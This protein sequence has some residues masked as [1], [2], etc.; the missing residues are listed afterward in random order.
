MLHLRLVGPWL[1]DDVDVVELAHIAEQ[2]LRGRDVERGQRRTGQVVRRAKA[3]ESGDCEG[4][5]RAL[6][7]DPDPLTHL[8]VVLLR[9]TEIH[10]HVVRRGRACSLGQVECRDLLVRVEGDAERWR[11]AGCDRLA[12]M[13][14]VLR[15]AGDRPP[16]RL[17]AGDGA[18][19]RHERLGDCIPGGVAAAPELRDPADLEVDVLVDVPEE[20]VER[21]VQRVGEHESPGDE[22]DAQHDRQSGEREAE[23]VREE[24]F[25]GHPPHV[26]SPTSALVPGRNRLSARR[27]RRRCCRQRGRR[28]GRRMQHHG[29][30]ASP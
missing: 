27:G 11:P 19:A 15:I 29:G 26:R 7:Q 16:C 14:D 1:R 12:V 28:R 6:Q 5:G 20:R 23:L 3:R 8:E 24:S 30:R 21:L 10:D 13:G 9:G 4:L 17:D 18:H 25:Q 22:R 2:C